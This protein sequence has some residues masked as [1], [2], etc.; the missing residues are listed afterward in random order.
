MRR[1]FTSASFADVVSEWTTSDVKCDVVLGRKM[2]MDCIA[3]EQTAAS[4]SAQLVSSTI[5]IFAA[6][7]QTT[8]FWDFAERD[9]HLDFVNAIKAREPRG[10]KQKARLNELTSPVCFE[11]GCQPGISGAGHPDSQ[12]GSRTGSIGNGVACD[13]PYLSQ[14]PNDVVHDF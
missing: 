7:Y 5:L 13:G 6:P 3:M 14:S 10:Q 8:V 2:L 12:R 11:P 4:K 9:G 1:Q